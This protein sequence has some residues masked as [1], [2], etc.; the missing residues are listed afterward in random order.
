MILFKIFLFPF[1]LI[2]RIF[3]NTILR[4][5][6]LFLLPQYLRQGFSKDFIIFMK[7]SPKYHPVFLRR[8]IP[9]VNFG[10]KTHA[11]EPVL[12]YPV[13]FIHGNSDKAVGVIGKHQSGWNNSIKYFLKRGYN[14]SELYGF[15]WGDASVSKAGFQTHSKQNLSCVRA[16]IELVLEYTKAEKVNIIAHSMGVTLARRA[17][18]GGQCYDPEYGFYELGKPLTSKVNTFIGIA[19]GNLGLESCKHW[20]KLLPT[21]NPFTGFYPGEYNPETK[22]VVNISKILQDMLDQGKF[23]GERVFS[24]WSTFDEVVQ[25]GG[26]VYD[27]PTC[28]LPFQDGEIVFESE[29]MNHFNLKLKTFREQFELINSSEN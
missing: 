24:I 16:F 3:R 22:K 5:L 23:E 13:I 12:K 11:Q 26:L 15:T 18:L 7:K 28:R 9:Y 19:G 14:F 29:E 25:N 21:C 1:L 10:G 20:S 6:A 8:D 17:I 27:R 2:F 4:F